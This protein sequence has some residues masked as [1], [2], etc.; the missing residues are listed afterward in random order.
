MRLKLHL[1]T[2]V[3][4]LAPLIFAGAVHAQDTVDRGRNAPADVERDAVS[5]QAVYSDGSQRDDNGRGRGSVYDGDTIRPLGQPA[6][7]DTSDRSR[8]EVMDT[9]VSADD[10]QIMYQPEPQSYQPDGN[11]DAGDAG[12]A[13]AIDCV[14]SDSGH[15]SGCYAEENDLNDQNFVRLALDNARQW[16]VG[17]QLR[18]GE[19]SA[20]R[21]FRLV[22]RFDRT[23][24]GVAPAIAS[25][26][27]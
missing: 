11:L 12:K 14:I 15:L 5:A 4:S 16:V 27:R 8:A 3:M 20:G 10:I 2:A 9:Y 25:N 18:N 1:L 24:S 13:I 26:G 6:D 17:P 23:N 7:R 22:C 21:T 19:P